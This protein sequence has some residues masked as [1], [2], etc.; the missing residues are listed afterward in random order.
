MWWFLLGG[1]V[2][3]EDR[4]A[5]KAAVAANTQP[6]YEAYMRNEP[7]GHFLEQAKTHIAT[8]ALA[9]DDNAWKAASATNTADAYQGYLTDFPNGKHVDAAQNGIKAAQRVALV[10]QAQQG[11]ATAGF[12]KGAIDG[13]E[14]AELTAAISAFWSSAGGQ[15][16]SAI[17][18]ALI[19]AL[20]VRNAAALQAQRDAEARAAREQQEAAARER[21]AYAKARLAHSRS[22]YEGFLT[23][24]P[25]GQ[26]ADD[27]RARLGQCRT[28]Q[29][30]ENVP[31]SSEISAQGT[32]QGQGHA[33][34]AYAVQN[35]R[36]A[37]MSRCSGGR[38][39][40]ITVA[41]Q[42]LSNGGAIASGVINLG[43]GII[44]KRNP[45]VNVNSSCTAT[46]NGTCQVN[47]MVNHSKEVCP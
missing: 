11:L 36:N 1:S 46:V 13:K 44:T 35:A 40:S 3:K 12:Y 17:D 28:Q 6:E 24:Y 15:P 8:L 10:M 45:N 14:S 16:S 4:E 20:N 42:Q 2:P 33:A 19:G 37:L 31:E 41:S 22:A 18:S 27:L 39:A 34:C 47:R 38:I 32:G 7:A 30:S 29:V 21:T 25:T 23:S 9:A 5:W 43:I 26:Y